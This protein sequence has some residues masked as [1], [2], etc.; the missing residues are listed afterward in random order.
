MLAAA[1][2]GADDVEQDGAMLPGHDRAGERWPPCARRSRRR[3]SRSSR[4][5]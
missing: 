4:P 2:G 5:S 3:A 1:D